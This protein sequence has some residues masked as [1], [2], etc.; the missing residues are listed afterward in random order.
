[1]INCQHV[2]TGQPL[3]D[4]GYLVSKVMAPKSGGSPDEDMSIVKE[5]TYCSCQVHRGV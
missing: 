1:M 5:Q 3:G 4:T 2:D